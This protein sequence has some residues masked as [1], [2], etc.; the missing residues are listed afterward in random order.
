MFFK[1]MNH[2]KIILYIIFILLCIYIFINKYYLNKE[3]FLNEEESINNIKEISNPIQYKNLLLKNLERGI[4]T[5]MKI[6]PTDVQRED[7]AEKCGEKDCKIMYEQKRNL[8]ACNMCHKNK[9]KCYK[10]SISG[11]NCEDCLDDEVQ[12]KCND[13]SNFGALNPN[14][15]FSK[16]GVDPYFVIKTTFSPNSNMSQECRF[17]Y[18][19]HD[20]I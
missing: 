10:K 20:L 8:D 18:D 12:M 11:G 13:V 6:K 9:K 2:I 3:Y 1:K 17:S 15:L 19:L 7:C 14:D 4:L 5:K 16:N